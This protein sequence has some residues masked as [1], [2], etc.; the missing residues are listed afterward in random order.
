M[1]NEDPSSFSPIMFRRFL[2]VLFWKFL[3]LY[4]VLSPVH[5]AF[6][7]APY[8]LGIFLLT[9]NCPFP[10]TKST[11]LHSCQSVEG[12][13]SSFDHKRSRSLA[14]SCGGFKASCPDLSP[15]FPPFEFL[16]KLFSRPSVA[17]RGEDPSQKKTLPSGE[18]NFLK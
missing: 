18:S 3:P 4:S 11:R 12:I 5:S 15:L 9:P 16:D 6:R 2:S 1:G 14:L 17:G 7:E 10:Y 8:I 13:A